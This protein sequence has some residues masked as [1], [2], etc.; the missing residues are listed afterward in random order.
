[1]GWV[2]VVCRVRGA[3]DDPAVLDHADN[4]RV[5]RGNPAVAV[6][7]IATGLSALAPAQRAGAQRLR[8]LARNVSAGPQ[9]DFRSWGL[10]GRANS[11]PATAVH[12]PQRS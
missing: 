9:G 5:D 6:L 1:V 4:T 3:A 2:D 12:D 7:T 10:T 11:R 8:A